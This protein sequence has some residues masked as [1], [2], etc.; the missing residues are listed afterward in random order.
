MFS[1]DDP[2]QTKSSDESKVEI[3]DI[4]EMPDFPLTMDM[5]Y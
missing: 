2:K 1:L 3:L 5:E 4:Q